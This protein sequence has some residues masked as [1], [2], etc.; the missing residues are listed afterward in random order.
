MA[1]KVLRP[2]TQYHCRDCKN[3]Y[4][5][6]EKNYR[7]EL[8]MCRCRFSEWCKFLS[9]NQCGKFELKEKDNG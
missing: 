4:D 9:D 7:G 2:V 3:S 6:H 5:W 8:F 1:K